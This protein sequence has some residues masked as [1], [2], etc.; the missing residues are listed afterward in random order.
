[1]TPNKKPLMLAIE[2]AEKAHATKAPEV[3]D[4]ANEAY[5]YMREA[6]LALEQTTQKSGFEK[7]LSRM[8]TLI[9]LK[10]PAGRAK[11]LALTKLEE[12]EL[13]GLRALEEGEHHDD[14]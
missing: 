1:M 9:E 2:A 6:E 11:S 4:L 3:L 13:W 8:R 7:T 14:Y 12:A 5:Q 10:L